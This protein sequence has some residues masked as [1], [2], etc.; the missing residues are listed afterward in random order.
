MRNL[1]LILFILVAGLNCF[2][3][4]NGEGKVT[5][6]TSQHIYVKFNSTEGLSEG[7]TLYIKQGGKEVPALQ[8]KNL[9]SISCV[10]IPLL[11]NAF[12]VSENVYANVK[13]KVD[14]AEVDEPL[15]SHAEPVNEL[16]ED[17]TQAQ[18]PG[19]DSSAVKQFKQD[20]SGRIS[21]SSYSN[22]NSET[23]AR[24]Q[25]MRYT[26]SLR[27][28]HLGNSKF[29]VESYLSFAHTNNNWDKVKE[30]IFNSLKI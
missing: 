4:Q 15:I 12:K 24:S 11:S 30:N 9:S 13:I 8:I 6:I 19:I 7:D 14:S 29:S 5:Y 28:N 20:I 2:G 18:S 3:Q 27:A 26:F 1:L 25:R 21:V 17:S 22:L 16:L 23:T 10:C